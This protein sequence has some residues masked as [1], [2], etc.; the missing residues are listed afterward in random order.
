MLG[1]QDAVADAEI[2]NHQVAVE[3]EVVGRIDGRHHLNCRQRVKL[4]AVV[5][6]C[7]IR[8]QLKVQR[9]IVGFRPDLALGAIGD[10]ASRDRSRSQFW[11]YT[12]FPP[13]LP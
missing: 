7:E 11:R 9:N 10:G 1:R 13:P 12:C 2:D 4:F 8:R 5:F 6:R 3:L